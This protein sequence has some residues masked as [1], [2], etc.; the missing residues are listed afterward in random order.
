MIF[1]DGGKLLDYLYNINDSLPDETNDEVLQNLSK[2][3]YYVEE[4]VKILE[5][6]KEVMEN[7]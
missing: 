2:A 1:I 5:Q 3:I 6:Y 4:R 7:S